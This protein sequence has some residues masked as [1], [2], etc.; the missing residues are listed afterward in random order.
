MTLPETMTALV[1]RE[2]GYAKGGAGDMPTD[3]S[4]FLE[5]T[6]LPVP[7]PKD[8]QALIKVARA[9]VN[10]SDLMFV[11]GQYGQP[12]KAGMPAGFE[13]AGEVVAGDTPLLGQ[14]VSFFGMGWGTWAEYAIAD[15]RM[16]IPLRPDL[17]DEDGAGLIVNPMTAMAMFDIVRADGAGAFVFT[18]GGSQLGKF[19]IGLAKDAGIAAVPVV[20]RAEQAETLKALGAADVLVSTSPDF[21]D[22]AKAVMAEHG[23]RI[24]LDAVAD[25]VTADLFSAMP[26]GARWVCYGRLATTP[27]R[28]DQM[29]QFIFMGKRIEGFWLSSWLR[30]TPPEKVAQLVGEVQA[31]FASGAWHTDV[32]E[33]LPLADALDRFPQVLAT[34]DAKVQI[35]P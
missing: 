19:L 10:P 14:R 4:S 25:Q 34:K 35:A 31:R 1:L 2:D 7:Q 23:P 29:G 9:A 20:R 13:G 24:L 26:R 22:R 32:S 28:L 33:V 16:M 6:T 27:P 3:L 12:R 15:T 11:S 21:A 8:G 18:A 30:E 17:K 5:L